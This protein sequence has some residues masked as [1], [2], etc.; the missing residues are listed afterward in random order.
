[1]NKE[2]ETPLTGEQFEGELG[3]QASLSMAKS[4]LR[5]GLIS[6]GEYSEIDTSLRASFRPFL[7]ELLAG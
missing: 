1:M 6:E 5:E 3:Y 7:S 4:M 2:K